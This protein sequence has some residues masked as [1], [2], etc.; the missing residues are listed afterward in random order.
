MVLGTPRGTNEMDNS[1]GCEQK[2]KNKNTLTVTYSSN[3]DKHASL[4]LGEQVGTV[5]CRRSGKDVIDQAECVFGILNIDG[6]S[7]GRAQDV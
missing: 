1:V 5:K 4:Q 2:I 6:M 7:I 3:R